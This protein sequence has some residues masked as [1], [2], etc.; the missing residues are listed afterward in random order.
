[1]TSLPRADGRT[2]RLLSSV[3]FLI[4]LV[5]STSSAFAVP[6][7]GEGGRIAS[8][9]FERPRRLAE[10]E[11]QQDVPVAIAASEEGALVGWQDAAGVS[12]R[13]LEPGA[14][15]TRVVRSR[16]VRGLWMGTAGGDPVVAWAERDLAT[17]RTALSWR[18]RGE[19]R[20]AMRTAQVP[21]LRLVRGAPEP[22]MLWVERREGEQRLAMRTWAGDVRR[23]PPR[24]LEIRGMDA[25][26]VGDTW[27]L[28]WL[29]G[30]DEIAL[31]R[32]EGRWTTLV[33]RWP[34]DAAAPAPPRRLGPARRDGARD[35]VRLE[36]S[37]SGEAEVELAWTRPDGSV[38]VVRADGGEERLG[39]GIPLVRTRAGWV[40][41]DGDRLVRDGPDG[42]RTVVR[43]PA[44][45]ERL[46]ASRAGGTT[47]LA[48]SAG[49]YRGGV[50][51]WGVR[52][53]RGYEP[54]VIERVATWMGWDPWRPWSAAGGHLLLSLLSAMLVGLALAP[55]WLIGA[56]LAARGGDRRAGRQALEGALV[57]VG[58]VLAGVALVWWGADL[59]AVPARDLTG[60]W[61]VTLGAACLGVLSA[62]AWGRRRDFD[63]TFGRLLTA[64]VA[65]TAMLFVLALATMPVW[66]RT[67]GI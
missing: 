47:S 65:G 26:R 17:G 41:L 35:R 37:A 18:W 44:A 57:G 42:P 31:G 30:R 66:L 9:G 1:M 3:A 11:L 60:G 7:A 24:T 56:A 40:W 62:W 53:E 50:E 67:F 25:I 63:A 52:D 27:W 39:R 33:A 8:G 48:W 58:T 21:R 45:P 4:T 61:A 59:E 5:A 64:W 15:P 13:R 54:T 46:E 12:V 43:L 6:P 51:V 36:P 20:T 2:L 19:E 23:A 32:E 34:R 14:A 22:E 28:A 55:L 49:S 16:G 10:V 29:E 38:R